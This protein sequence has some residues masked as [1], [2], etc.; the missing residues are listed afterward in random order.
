MKNGEADPN[1][2]IMKILL[3]P[4][5]VTLPS[6]GSSR[7]RFLSYLKGVETWLCRTNPPPLTEIL[8]S[9]DCVA[10]LMETDAFPFSHN[11]SRLVSAKGIIEYDPQ[12][13]SRM[14]TS[15]LNSCEPIES[16]VWVLSITAELAVLPSYLIDR[17]P[18]RIS[19]SFRDCLAKL[20]LQTSSDDPMLSELRIG[21]TAQVTPNAGEIAIHGTVANAQVS[22][23]DIALDPMPIQLDTE[24]PLLFDLEDVLDVTGWEVLWA[25]PDWAIRKA[26]YSVTSSGDRDIYRLGDFKTGSRFLDTI[27][28]LGLH[29]Q[30][31]RIGS[32]YRTCALVI[33]GYAPRVAGINPRRLR[34]CV[35]D[36]DGAIGLRADISQEGSGYRLHYW[37]C[38]EGT[39][40]LSCVNVHNDVTIYQ[41]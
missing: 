30:P 22:R 35:R 9:A 39:I 7:D 4:Y 14:A 31:G 40:E 25:H 1:R 20:A 12:A 2:A 26:Y 18:K 38:Q 11:L 37:R 10:G 13:I 34:C 33:S 32:I 17:L 21:S 36:S 23:T 8:Y 24:F 3:D 19:D 6:L 27:R 28:D 15:L 16:Y 5:I 41:N 29:T